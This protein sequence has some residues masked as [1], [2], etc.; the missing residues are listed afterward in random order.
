M[1]SG[2]NKQKRNHKQVTKIIKRETGYE[3]FKREQ[4]RNHKQARASPTSSPDG[5]APALYGML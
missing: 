5:G 2:K 4:K 3:P 1:P